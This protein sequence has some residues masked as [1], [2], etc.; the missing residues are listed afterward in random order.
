MR[1]NSPAKFPDFR[2][3]S[4]QVCD[5]AQCHIG[6]DATITMTRQNEK[7]AVSELLCLFPGLRHRQNI[8]INIAR[9]KLWIKMKLLQSINV[10][11]SQFLGTGWSR[12]TIMKLNYVKGVEDGKN[13][14]HRRGSWRCYR[15]HY[16]ISL[17][18]KNACIAN[19]DNGYDDN[20]MISDS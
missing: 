6:S 19:Q 16:N 9:N 7:R 18:I 5:Y 2:H 12:D 11:N 17:P 4:C 8:M 1:T 20:W 13:I 14:S 10:W 3:F 15:W